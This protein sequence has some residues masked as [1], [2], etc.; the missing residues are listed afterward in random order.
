MFS[1]IFALV[2]AQSVTL[3]FCWLCEQLIQQ[4]G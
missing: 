1:T 3:V 2:A 4:Y